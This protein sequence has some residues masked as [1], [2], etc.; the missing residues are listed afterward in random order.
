LIAD[1]DAVLMPRRQARTA[2]KSQGTAIK[3][4]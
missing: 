1:F 2:I 4:R 3:Y